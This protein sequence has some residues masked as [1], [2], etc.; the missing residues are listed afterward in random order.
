MQN[1]KEVSKILKNTRM[2]KNYGS[3]IYCDSCN[4]TVAY[5]CYTTYEYF[6]F[7]YECNC[8]NKG[9]LEIGKKEPNHK[10]PKKNLLINKGRLC[11]PNDNSPLFSIVDKNIKKYKFEFT[12]KNC[13][14][15]Y[16]EKNL[17]LN[18]K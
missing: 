11:C 13:R 5:L 17:Q 3:W 2:L 7:T 10:T 6:K 18:E 15:I 8:K 14:T 12:C 16:N 1:K 4:K 9:F